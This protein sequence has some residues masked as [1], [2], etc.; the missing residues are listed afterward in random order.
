[1]SPVYSPLVILFN[2]QINTL[3]SPPHGTAQRPAPPPFPATY[4]HQLGS[5]GELVLTNA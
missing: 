4:T 5:W 2:S 3:K 1:M